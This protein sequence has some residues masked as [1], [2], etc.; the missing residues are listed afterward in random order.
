[1]LTY[2]VFAFI[3]GLIAFGRGWSFWAGFLLSLIGTPIIGIIFVLILGH[4]INPA[5]GK[6]W[7]EDDTGYFD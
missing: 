4:K 2:I 1:M 5:N 3:V 7:H 6:R